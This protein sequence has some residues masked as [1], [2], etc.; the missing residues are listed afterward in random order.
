MQTTQ[1]RSTQ[2]QSTTARLSNS[3]RI[4][5]VLGTVLIGGYAFWLA[6]NLHRS[7]TDVTTVMITLLFAVSFGLSTGKSLLTFL[8]ARKDRSHRWAHFFAFVC[9]LIVASLFIAMAACA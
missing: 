5:V 9:E 2:T 8:E 3:Q 7:H 1:S 4:M 6:R